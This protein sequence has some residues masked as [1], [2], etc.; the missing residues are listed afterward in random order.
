MWDENAGK[1]GSWEAW[2]LGGY[3]N[4]KLRSREVGQLRKERR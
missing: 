4:K 3:E 1:P 2:K